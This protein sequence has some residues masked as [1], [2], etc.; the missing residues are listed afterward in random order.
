MGRAK[1][2]PITILLKAMEIYLNEE[3][4]S[5]ED[6]I[7]KP[8]KEIRLKTIAFSLRNLMSFYGYNVSTSIIENRIN[9][10]SFNAT[11]YQIEDNSFS[12]CKTVMSLSFELICHWGNIVNVLDKIGH[13]PEQRTIGDTQIKLVI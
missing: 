2:S 9:I 1:H 5:V 12:Q 4:I 8:N 7:K 10:N 13:L 6:I 3:N 11:V